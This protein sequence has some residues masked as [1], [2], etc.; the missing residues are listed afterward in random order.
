MDIDERRG[1]LFDAG[2]SP[3][4]EQF[5]VIRCSGRRRRRYSAGCVR[6]VPSRESALAEARPTEGLLAAVVAGP[7]KSSEN[8]EI[9]YLLRW[10]DTP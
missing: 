3:V 1:D 10:L 4:R 9:Y 2:V 6:V 5:A 8:V 7:S